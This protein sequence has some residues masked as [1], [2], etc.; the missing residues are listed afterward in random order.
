MNQTRSIKSERLNATA[1]M[2]LLIGLGVGFAAPAAAQEGSYTGVYRVTGACLQTVGA[3]PRQNETY[4]YFARIRQ[5]SNR[6]VVKLTEQ[7]RSEQYAQFYVG[8]VRP[9]NASGSGFLSDCGG[10]YL[11]DELIHVLG[12]GEGIFPA[13]SVFTTTQYP[14]S[15]NVRITA[16]CAYEFE[17][18]RSTTPAFA[19]CGGTGN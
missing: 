10:G 8:R 4:R 1:R 13:N 6:L 17:R 7:G 16:T 9:A 5:E 2:C 11:R 19:E 14:D 3:Q 12:T 15:P 18:I